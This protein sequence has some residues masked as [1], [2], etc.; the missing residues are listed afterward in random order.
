M[1]VL[2]I[3]AVLALVFMAAGILT[4]FDAQVSL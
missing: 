3:R 1:R 4:A 2:L